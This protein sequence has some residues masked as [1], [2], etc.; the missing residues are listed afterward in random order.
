MTTLLLS[1]KYLH[2]MANGLAMTA[3]VAFIVIIAATI[4]GFLLALARNSTH[5]GL[6]TLATAYVQIFR[7][8]PLLIQLFFWYFGA[9]NLL[10]ESAMT[11]LNTPHQWPLPGITLA[12]PSFEF[13]AAVF[14][15]TLYATAFIAEDIRSG[16]RGVPGA[17]ME[18]GLSTGLTHWQTL[19]YIVLP[20]ALRI[21]Q[22][23]L[24]GQYM[25]IVKNSSL[26]MGIG[27]AELSY[28]SRQVEAASFLTFQAFGVATL[29]YIGIIALIE[30]LSQFARRRAALPGRA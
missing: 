9:P 8:T 24:F 3:W 19:R 1:P 4:S 7:N 12:W 23:P 14:G 13:L 18:A 10:P 22:P 11:W 16:L 20:Q 27:L 17:Q 26:T 5:R 29:G 21:T 15:L 28:T 2:W 6:R 25:N 30:A